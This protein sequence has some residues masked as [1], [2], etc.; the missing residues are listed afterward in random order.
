MEPS[1]PLNNNSNSLSPRP[2]LD[3]KPANGEVTTATDQATPAHITSKPIQLGVES[4]ETTSVIPR[5]S[6]HT[7]EGDIFSAIKDENY[8]N[9]IVK[10]V[11]NP[12]TNSNKSQ[13]ADVETR[14]FLKKVAMASAIFVLLVI[15]AFGYFY[16][17]GQREAGT[18]L[19][20]NSPIATSTQNGVGSTSLSTIKTTSVLEA[21]AIIQLNLRELDKASGIQKIR[22]IQQELRDK[23]IAVGTTV[24]LTLGLTVPELFA[25]NQYS[26]G[27]GLIRSL[28]NNYS[29]GLYNNKESRFESFLV[30]KISSSDLAFS[31]MLDWERYLPADL[32]DL[33]AD[34]S[35][36]NPDPNASQTVSTT[37]SSTTT[38]PVAF[39]TPG[40]TDKVLRNTDAR[41]YT[42]TNGK[43]QFVYG[44]VNKDYLIISGGI[45]SFV[46]VKTR[47]LNNNTLR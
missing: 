38:A 45:E 37:T 24:E 25:K 20:P 12:S 15:A 14:G 1:K 34:K 17:A 41:V 3:P 44:F 36:V 7:L 40:F 8:A 33:F 19:D 11:T 28:T 31:N 9:N 43:V 23:Q 42:D 35:V 6:I 26:G 22:Q 32:T 29:F 13:N 4:T 30:F 47:L 39:L 18:N 21:E 46:D 27:E 16:I 10:I 2:A 5:S